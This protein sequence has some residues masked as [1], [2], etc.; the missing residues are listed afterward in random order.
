MTEIA[1]RFDCHS[2]LARPVG[3]TYQLPGYCRGR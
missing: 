2:S 1:Q 3:A